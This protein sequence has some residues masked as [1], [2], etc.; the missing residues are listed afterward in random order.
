[1]KITTHG[2]PVDEDRLGAFFAQYGP[3][4]EVPA[5]MSKAGIATGDFVLYITLT[6]Q[7]FQDIPNILKCRDK[8]MPIVVEG[9]RPYSWTCG[10]LEHMSKVCSGKK[11]S[12]AA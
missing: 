7:S 10:S 11:S 6:R 1:M 8:M 3:V 9:R 12:T 4:E 5:I 2:V